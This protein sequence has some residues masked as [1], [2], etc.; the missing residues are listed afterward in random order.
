V[1]DRATAF[2]YLERGLAG[3]STQ[4]AVWDRRQ[5]YFEGRQD[6][7]FAPEG[8]N[9]EYLDLREMA[10]GN[11]LE[12]AMGAPVQRMVAEGF[13]TGRGGE[14]DLK[15]W[16]E[17]WQPNK[18]DS[19]Q[20]IVYQQMF[21]HGRGM[22]SVS[23]NLLNPKSPKIRPENAKRIWIEPDPEDPFTPLFAVK[24]LVE[25]SLPASSGL[26]LP[27]RLIR[28]AKEVAYV[29]TAE[30]W[31]KFEC[32]GPGGAWQQVDQKAHSLRSLP[33]VPFDFN[34]DADGKPR[35][36][37]TKLM[38]Q[39]DAVN[40]IRFNTLLAMQFSAYRQRIFTAYDPVVRDS[41]GDPLVKMKDGAPV[42][43][44][45]G[46]QIPITRSP[47][48]VG[49]DRALVFPGKDTK[50]YDL[51]E[52]N[53]DN[54]ITALDHFLTAL[55]STGQIPPQYALNKMANTSGDAMAGA[56]ATF[57]S[58]IKDLKVSAAESIETVM[59]LSN[60]ARGEDHDDVAAEVIWGDS[61]IRS[62]AQIVDGIG[63]LI[64]SGMSRADA[65][66][67]LP[68]ATPPR[69]SEWVKNSNEDQA[70]ADMGLNALA[71]KLAISA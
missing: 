28:K 10:I 65:W 2:D 59:N 66:A 37:I 53:L 1:L 51:P 35:A 32:P 23:G 64:T 58:L 19:R 24:K 33:F 47:G 38:P 45:N 46:L 6:L 56:E 34:V 18:L 69:V 41:K 4:S 61:E 22:M 60:Q 11:Y 68:G 55:F 17:V 25:E 31:I 27:G 21:L 52:S 26:I 48:R 67:M 9:A 62:F 13:K 12:L 36:A 44:S 3:I 8:V 20:K 63:K 40:T 5:D 43:D 14:A 49:V 70:Q 57:Q 16:D 71:D 30:E 50:V 54:Y 29:Y 15:A 42:L 7:P 39:Q